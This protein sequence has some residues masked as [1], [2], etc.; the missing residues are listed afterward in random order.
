MSLRKISS[1]RL[2]TRYGQFTIYVFAEGARDHVALVHGKKNSQPPL[3]RVHS[4]CLTGD[5]FGSLRCD[6]GPQLETSLRRLAKAKHGILLYLN[7]EGR[8]I[9]LANKIKAY[10]LQ[11]KGLDTMEANEALGLPA[12]ARRYDVAAH[13]LKILGVKKIRLLTNNPDKECQLMGSG[14]N[15][16][17]TE[18]LE[19]KPG[20]HNRQYLAVKKKKFGHRLTL[21]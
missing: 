14:I 17:G 11:D 21:V 13:M 16:A 5:T 3:V 1:A 15:V 7:Q 4:Q 8:G 19:I 10:A 9:G 12:D 18:G 2:P 20:R 6:C